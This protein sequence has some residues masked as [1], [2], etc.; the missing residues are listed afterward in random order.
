M[1]KIILTSAAFALLAFGM[2]S[3]KRGTSTL[4]INSQELYYDLD[5][6]PAKGWYSLTKIAKYD[7]DEFCAQ[8]NI[9]KEWLQNMTFKDIQFDIVS[10]QLKFTDYDSIGVDVWVTGEDTVKIITKQVMDSTTFT[11]DKKSATF[12][13]DSTFNALEYVSKGDV[14]MK[15][16]LHAAHNHVPAGRVHAT[17]H[18]DVLT[19]LKRKLGL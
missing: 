3:C 14:Y 9:K 4:A 11:A 8:N 13:T 16:K 10:G 12:K 7:V 2:H 18:V 19:E 5:S 15:V 17:P 1:K 6:I